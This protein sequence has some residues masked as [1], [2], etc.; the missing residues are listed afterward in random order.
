MKARKFLVYYFSFLILRSR[1]LKQPADDEL[2]LKVLHG[3]AMI[4]YLVS[5]NV[6]AIL[7]YIGSK[8]EV[9][10]FVLFGTGSSAWL[11]YSR[12]AG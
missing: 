4:S 12:S 6:W 7:I 1:K 11:L 2:S 8:T 3:A 9:D 5:L 10:P